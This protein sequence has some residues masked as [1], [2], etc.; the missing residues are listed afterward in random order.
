MSDT[1]PAVVSSGR[2]ALYL[3]VSGV[4]QTTDNQRPELERLARARGLTIV[5]T[6]E[7][8]ASA[9]KSRSRF[10][11]MMVDAHRGAFDV[12]LVRRPVGLPEANRRAGT[13]HR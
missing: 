12:L 3:R 9:A 4:D 7:E 8:Q 2:A 1:S 13:H 5:A 6:Y 11:A 10:E